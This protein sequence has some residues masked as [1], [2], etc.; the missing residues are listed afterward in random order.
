MTL[1]DKVLGR[2]NTRSLTMNEAHPHSWLDAGT[3]GVIGKPLDRVEGPLKVSGQATYAAEYPVERL[4]YG[5]LVRAPFGSG[6]ITDV[7]ADAARALPG[8]IDVITDYPSFI[9]NPQQGGEK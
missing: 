2:E 1:I 7:V 9:R 6:K 4:S 5:V 3:Q 8:V